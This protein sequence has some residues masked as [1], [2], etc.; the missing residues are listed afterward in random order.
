MQNSFLAE[1]VVFM[2]NWDILTAEFKSDIISPLYE[3]FPRDSELILYISF[4][5]DLS[6]E[7]IQK[8][9]KLSNPE[10]IIGIL[11]SLLYKALNNYINL[12]KIYKPIWEKNKLEQ[13]FRNFEL[14]NIHS[15]ELMKNF[16]EIKQNPRSFLQNPETFYYKTNYKHQYAPSSS[17]FSSPI[18]QKMSKYSENLTFDLNNPTNNEVK[19]DLIDKP[20]PDLRMNNHVFRSFRSFGNLNDANLESNEYKSVSFIKENYPPV[21][22]F[23]TT[24]DFFVSAYNDRRAPEK[25]PMANENLEFKIKEQIEN[26]NKAF[27]E[28]KEKL[29][30]QYSVNQPHKKSSNEK[31][32]PSHKSVLLRINNEHRNE[33]NS[34]KNSKKSESQS[35]SRSSSS[36]SSSSLSH[37][38]NKKKKKNSSQD[39]K[40]KSKKTHRISKKHSKNY[41]LPKKKGPR[42][43]FEKYLIADSNRGTGGGHYE[44]Q[45]LKKYKGEKLAEFIEKVSTGGKAIKDFVAY[46]NIF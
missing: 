26:D 3:Q 12:T 13:F 29:M 5:C 33:K 22:S 25:F 37:R 45:L 1:D 7:E 24:N 35:K 6:L 16:I 11:K 44:R 39:S 41:S 42:E 20:S 30:S 18:N 14:K 43:E 31:Q 4:V 32:Q 40:S 27:E 21:E 34:S 17:P 38:S 19:K 36:E 2:K 8:K 9:F 10:E 28:R 23:L 15:P 46:S